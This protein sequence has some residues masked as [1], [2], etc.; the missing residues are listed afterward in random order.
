MHV[1]GAL[2]RF[3]RLLPDNFGM[4]PRNLMALLEFDDE[5]ARKGG[6]PMATV[7]VPRVAR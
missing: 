1:V 2:A 5:L 7:S 4:K 3:D 6:H